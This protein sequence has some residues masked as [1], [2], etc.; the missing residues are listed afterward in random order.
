MQSLK[1]VQLS[2]TEMKELTFHLEAAKQK[3]EEQEAQSE[4]ASEEAICR[5]KAEFLTQIME[6]ING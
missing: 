3:L 6:K 2:M 1:T 5:E 4:D